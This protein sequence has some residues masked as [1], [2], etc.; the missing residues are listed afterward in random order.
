[1]EILAS[2]E[3]VRA[4]CDARR[5][6]GER[7]G[8]VPTMGY[9]HEGHLSLMRLARTRADRLLVSIFVNPTQFGPNEDL[10]RYPRD[11]EGDAA[12]CR[13]VG[14][15]VLFMPPVSELYADDAETFVTVEEVSR[16]LCGE[17]RPTHFRGVCTVVT[18]LFNIV[19]PC[20]A[21]FGEKDYQQLQ[22]VRRMAR[23]LL[24]PVEIVSG[25][26]VR[27]PDG[28]AMSSRNAYLSDAQRRGARGLSQ[29]LQRV[30]ERVASGAELRA[31]EAV[32]LARDHILDVGAREGVE[33]KVDYISL[34]RPESLRPIDDESV[35]RGGAAVMLLAVFFGATRLIDNREL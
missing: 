19:G 25:P 31:G 8:F 2:V 17:R 13:E 14:T 32:A 18:K 23:D 7:I 12:T 26:L 16:G 27:E 22:V 5:A 33:P 10:A 3:A 4:Y 6:A 24:Q 30:A 15:D 29:A 34:R 9:L 21:V 1:M 28:V 20:V 35:L 11:A